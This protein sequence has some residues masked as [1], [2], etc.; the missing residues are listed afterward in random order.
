MQAAKGRG[1]C[2]A[3]PPLYCFAMVMASEACL[4]G[5]IFDAKPVQGAFEGWSWR[6]LL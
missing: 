2:K 1:E 4:T 3:L 5:D 6:K